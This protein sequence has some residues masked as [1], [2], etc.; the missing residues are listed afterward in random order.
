MDMKQI[1]ELMVAL[2]KSGLKKIRIKEEK[3]FEVELEKHSEQPAHVTV[4]PEPAHH[5][6]PP[7]SNPPHKEGPK[8][9]KESAPGDYVSSPM[10]GTYY[11]SPS[12][13]DPSYVKVGDV[14]DE[15]TVI[16]IIEA[17]KVINEVKAGKKGK[18]AEILVDNADPVEFG[19]KLI[20]II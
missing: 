15:D 12:P 16:C 19:S 3:G 1:K 10:V 8:E 9:A 13:D 20:R 6:A 4:R 18:V 14:V 11:S 5:F 17:M 2:E 7:P